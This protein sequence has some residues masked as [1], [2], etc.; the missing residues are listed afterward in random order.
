MRRTLVEKEETAVASIA[1]LVG[2]PKTAVRNVPR[3][4]RG[5]L[6]LGVK[7]VHWVMPEEETTMMRPNAN[8]VINPNINGTFNLTINDTI[9]DTDIHNT[10]QFI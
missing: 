1:Q 8:N 7:I 10:Y 5:G 9:D 2:R 6:V 4:E 3:V